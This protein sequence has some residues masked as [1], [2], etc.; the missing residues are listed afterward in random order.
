MQLPDVSRLT[1]E[2][3]DAW[4]VVGRDPRRDRQCQTGAVR[5]LPSQHRRSPHRPRSPGCRAN[6]ADLA[7]AARVLDRVDI[8]RQVLN[9]HASLPRRCEDTSS[10]VSTSSARKTSCVAPGMQPS[11]KP[12]DHCRYGDVDVPWSPLTSI[13]ARVN[14]SQAHDG[15]VRACREKRTIHLVY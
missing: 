13:V 6:G 8:L 10:N 3:K 1:H 2:E 5:A 4:T 12:P 11:P 9:R 7:A 15:P 14:R